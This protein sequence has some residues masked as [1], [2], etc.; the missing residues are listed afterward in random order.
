[1][2]VRCDG[3]DG[4]QFRVARR[5][6]V[7]PPPAV[8]RGLEGDARA[9]RRH[10][11]RARARR[12]SA[13][14]SPPTTSRR[15]APSRRARPP[16]EYLHSLGIAP[17]DFVNY[18]ARRLNHDVMIRG[19]FANIRIAQRNDAGRA[20]AATRVH[21]PGRRANADLRRRAALPQRRRAARD[22][23][24]RGIRRRFVARLG[25]QGRAPA[26]RAR[27]DRGIL[28]AHP[29]LQPGRHGRAAAAV[30]D[31]ASRARRSR[32]TAASCSTSAGSTQR[33]PAQRA[34]MHDYARGRQT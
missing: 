2:A 25:G 26:G 23:R 3:A 15:S 13:T 5:E 14:C 27:G 18:A 29:S 4:H 7:H 33:S 32:S 24:R 30:R 12:C 6:H 1:M 28:R 8:L 31:R 19:T 34:R 9:G 17:R 22:H 11:R 16:R 21:L 20:K 10:P